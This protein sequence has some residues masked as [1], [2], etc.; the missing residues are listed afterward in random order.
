M[1]EWPKAWSLFRSN[2]VARVDLT[3]II[4]IQSGQKTIFFDKMKD[5]LH[6]YEDRSFSLIYGNGSSKSLDFIAPTIAIQKQWYECLKIL[7]KQLSEKALFVSPH[8]RY[9][10]AK[11]DLADR[12]GDGSLTKKEILNLVHK[13]NISMPKSEVIKIYNIVDTDKSN[14]LNYQEFCAFMRI[15]CRRYVA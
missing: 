3:H 10:N 14:S 4:R 13:I 7:I 8:L 1:L 2:K 12:D 6:K 5:K 9:V 11:W 15:L